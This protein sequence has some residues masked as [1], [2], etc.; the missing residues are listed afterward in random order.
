MFVG[1]VVTQIIGI[2]NAKR[3]PWSYLL[4]LR[5][6]GRGEV[7]QPDGQHS[8]DDSLGE[9]APDVRHDPVVVRRVP[10]ARL[11][12]DGDDHLGLVAVLAV[13][14]E[15]VDA[16][17]DEVDEERDGGAVQPQRERRVQGRTAT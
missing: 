4:H 10:R 15:G 3:S 11:E 1:E 16:L 5:G 8:V 17:A 13:E 9:A 14:E 6:S 2:F 7:L 12:E